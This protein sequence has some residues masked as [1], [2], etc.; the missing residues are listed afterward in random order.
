MNEHGLRF[1]DI[2]TQ[3]VVTQP[4]GGKVECRSS[5]LGN[6]GYILTNSID[7]CVVSKEKCGDTSDG[8]RLERKCGTKYGSLRHTRRH[9]KGI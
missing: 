1:L 8:F 9:S 2:E 5:G 7:G 6:G 4:F 3:V